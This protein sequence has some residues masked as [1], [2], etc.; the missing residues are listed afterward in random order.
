MK[1]QKNYPYN[2][3]VKFYTIREMLDLSVQDNPDKIAFEYKENKKNLQKTYKE[4]QEET[5]HL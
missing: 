2:E 4:F 3:V 1:S 5:F